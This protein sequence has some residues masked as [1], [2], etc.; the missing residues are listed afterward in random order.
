MRECRNVGLPVKLRDVIDA[1]DVPVEGWASYVHRRTGE[2]V[3]YPEAEVAPYADG[4]VSSDWQDEFVADA[5]RVA[6]SDDFRRLPDK[7]EIHE[8]SL[9]ERFCNSV[10]DETLCEDLL[11]AIRGSGAFRRFKGMIRRHGLEQDWWS[12]RDAAFEKIAADFLEAE[13]IPFERS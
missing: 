2:I 11:D 10:E 6:A 5:K 4:D 9:M 3:S 8:Y 7:F 1:M 13:G 12:Y